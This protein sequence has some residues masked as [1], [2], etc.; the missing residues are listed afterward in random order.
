MTLPYVHSRHDS[1]RARIGSFY[2][3]G[4]TLQKRSIKRVGARAQAR[5]RTRIRREQGTSKS[6]GEIDRTISRT[7]N[8]RSLSIDRLVK[9]Q[10]QASYYPNHHD[11]IVIL[12]TSIIIMIAANP[13]IPIRTV[14][15][16]TFPSANTTLPSANTT[17]LSTKPFGR[18]IIIIVIT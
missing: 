8:R 16:D 1:R 6:R 17:L 13:A 15:Y 11:Y 9:I 2:R 10:Q 18:I 5:A 7:A 14:T 4:R 12:S 3:R